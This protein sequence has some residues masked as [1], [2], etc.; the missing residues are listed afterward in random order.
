MGAQTTWD[1]LGEVGRRFAFLVETYGMAGPEGDANS[2]LVQYVTTELVVAIHYG[3]DPHDHAGQRI[4]VSVSP[5]N[6][7]RAELPDL[8]EAAVFAPR[9]KVAWKAHTDDA[10]RATLDEQALWLRRLMPL[11]V[12]SDGVDLIRR[13]NARPTDR[14]GNPQRRSRNIKW[15]YG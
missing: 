7:Y 2:S 11:L 5:V 4:D 13:A 15:T 6:V 1:F 8:V 9:H 14:A 10:A 12:E 3:H